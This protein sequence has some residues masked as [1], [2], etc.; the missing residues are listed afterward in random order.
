VDEAMDDLP[1]LPVYDEDAARAT[2]DWANVPGAPDQ[3]SDVPTR[4][5]FSK[6]FIPITDSDP[7]LL[8]G[9]PWRYPSRGYLFAAHDGCLREHGNQT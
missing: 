3:L 4:C 5:A 8:I 1:E 9:K 2:D 6:E 7:V